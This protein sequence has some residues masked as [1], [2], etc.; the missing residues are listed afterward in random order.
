LQAY[1]RRRDASNASNRVAIGRS[2]RKL[3]PKNQFG[4]NPAATRTPTP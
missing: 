2:V 4:G 1:S 3:R